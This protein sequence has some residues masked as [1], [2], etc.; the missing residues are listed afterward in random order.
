MTC[1]IYAVWYPRMMMFTLLHT[2]PEMFYY[3][4]IVAK[5]SSAKPNA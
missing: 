1:Y 3:L 4:Q 2:I 5:K